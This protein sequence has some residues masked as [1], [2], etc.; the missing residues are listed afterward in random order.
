MILP[1]L[2]LGHRVCADR[3]GRG[4]PA[5]RGRRTRTPDA[6]RMRA[7]L[8]RT[9]Q[10]PQRGKWSEDSRRLWARTIERDLTPVSRAF[11]LRSTQRA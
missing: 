8:Q 11:I 6:R 9:I 5:K 1:C 10:S 3:L 2:A 7:P 4:A